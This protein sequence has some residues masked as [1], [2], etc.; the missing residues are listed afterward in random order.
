MTRVD[1]EA[2]KPPLDP[3]AREALRI[4]IEALL[5]RMRERQEKQGELLQENRALR[6]ESRRLIEEGRHDRQR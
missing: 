2:E 6:A 3:A 4:V 1:R 5:A